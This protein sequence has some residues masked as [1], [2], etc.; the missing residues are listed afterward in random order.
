VINNPNNPT[1]SIVPK[2]KLEEI[3]EIAREKDIIILSDEVYRPLFHSIGPGDDDFPPSALNAGYNKAIVTGSLSKAYSLAGI[4][5]GWIACRNKEILEACAATRHYTNISVSRLDEA[6]A[7]EALS[8]RCLH[9]L[10]GRN[11]QLAKSNLSMLEAFIDEHQWACSWVKPVAGTTTFIKFAKMGKPVDDEVFCDQLQQ[12]T[13]V[14]FVPGSKC[15]GRGQ[16]FKGYVRIGF[17]QEK[18]VLEQGLA[19]LRS[20]MEESFADL[21]TAVKS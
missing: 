1:G 10:L 12:K 3:A 4:R 16:D 8:E 2:R 21:P 20:F 14:M 19:A 13:G 18:E 5:T 7:A 17:V 15:F 11:I 9:S 6:V